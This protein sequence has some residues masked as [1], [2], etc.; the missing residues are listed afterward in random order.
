[1]ENNTSGE[2]YIMKTSPQTLSLVFFSKSGGISFFRQFSSVFS[3]LFFKHRDFIFHCLASLV[4]GAVFFTLIII[5]LT[6]LAEH[7]W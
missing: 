2:E 1:M 4:I 5:F 3:G 7:G 6:Q